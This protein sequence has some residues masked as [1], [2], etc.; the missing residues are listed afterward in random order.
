[1]GDNIVDLITVYAD[2]V[3]AN[4]IS[5]MKD[6]LKSLSFMGSITHQ[7]VTRS[8]VPVLTI[9]AKEIHIATGFSASGG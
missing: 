8:K 1:M 3:D 4:M 2:S 9:S 7:I 6:Q 5:I